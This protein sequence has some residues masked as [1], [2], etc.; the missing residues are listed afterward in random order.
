MLAV[1]TK[2]AKPCVSALWVLMR[3]ATTAAANPLFR[4]PRR[5]G[6][7]ESPALVPTFATYLFRSIKP[8]LI[9]IAIT[10]KLHVSEKSPFLQLDHS[11]IQSILTYL[12]P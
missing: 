12:S 1:F 8:V 2:S 3:C 10:I 9:G 11:I 6:T 5:F 4:R 7:S